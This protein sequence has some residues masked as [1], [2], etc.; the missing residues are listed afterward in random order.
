M[1]GLPSG[2]SSRY[3]DSEDVRLHV[4]HNVRPDDARPAILFLHGFPEYWAGWRPVM[5]RLAGDYAVIAPDQRG[6]N[7][8]DAPQDVGAYASKKLVADAMAIAAA[9]AGGRRIFLAGHDWGAAVAYAL[10]IGHGKR[11]AGLIIANGVHPVLF[12]KAL[13]ED[14]GQRNA[15]QYFHYFRDE[16]AAE[17]MSEDDFKRTFS[18]FEKFSDAPW[19]TDA[20]REGYRNAW[21][22]PGRMNAML[23]WYRAAPIVVPR[24]GADPGNVPLAQGLPDRFGIPIPHLL[25]WGDKDQAL[26]PVSF[27]GLDK[28]ARDLEVTRI[29]EAGHWLIHERPDRIAQL[30][31]RFIRG[32]DPRNAGR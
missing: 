9:M 2:F 13:L 29:N 20:T 22:R 16:R 30:M 3:V 24:P 14:S 18:M 12:Q 28:F 27:A 23:N 25:I 6:Y 10:A 8:S 32:H 26:L 31:D 1:D 19:L 21:A 11:F 5:E 4:V 15:S 7:L 17:S